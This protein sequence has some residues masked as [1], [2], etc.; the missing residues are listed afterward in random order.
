VL[1]K[2]Q[3]QWEVL[4]RGPTINVILMVLRIIFP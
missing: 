1:L 3:F 4:P 2:K